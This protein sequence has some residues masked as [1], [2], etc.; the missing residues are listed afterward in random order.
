MSTALLAAP[1]RSGAIIREVFDRDGNPVTA[2]LNDGSEASVEAI[3][4]LAVEQGLGH[5]LS[6]AG[7]LYLDLPGKRWPDRVGRDDWF[8]AGSGNVGVFRPIAFHR[9]F[10]ARASQDA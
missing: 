8:V 5:D 4:E 10:T 3:I 7:H 2:V 9:I 6:S 1:A